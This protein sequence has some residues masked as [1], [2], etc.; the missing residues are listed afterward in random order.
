[1]PYVIGFLIALFIALTG[2]GAGTI[3]LA[4]EEAP[5]RPT[6]SKLITVTE[7]GPDLYLNAT[8]QAM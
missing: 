4:L 5:G 2:V 3:R 7:K 8:I 1:M 6:P